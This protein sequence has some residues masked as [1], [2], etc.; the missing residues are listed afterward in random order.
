MFVTRHKFGQA[1]RKQCASDSR[2]IFHDWRT[3]LFINN[4][5]ADLRRKIPTIFWIFSVCNFVYSPTVAHCQCGQQPTVQPVLAERS[6]IVHLF[7]TKKGRKGL[8]IGWHKNIWNK[9]TESA[10]STCAPVAP[11]F[12]YG[13]L[14]F[15]IFGARVAE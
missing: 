13:P 12:L 6:V 14:P 3:S 9:F 11:T 10:P 2:R 5:R 8:L 1:F 4:R 7:S 15:P